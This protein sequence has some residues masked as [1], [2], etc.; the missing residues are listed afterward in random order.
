MVEKNVAAK[1]KACVP[2]SVLV[3]RV[4]ILY[5]GS[6][7]CFAREAVYVALDMNQNLP[8]TLITPLQK[9]HPV[10]LD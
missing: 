4:Y 3:L 6:V 8:R 7:V 5:I 2:E 1:T 9:G 10:Q